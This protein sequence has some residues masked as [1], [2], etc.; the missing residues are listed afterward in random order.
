MG[1]VKKTPTQFDWAESVEEIA[2]DLIPKYH[3]HLVNAK[4]AYLFK[5][6]EIKRGGKIVIA[7]AEKCGPKVKALAEYDF[8]ITVAYPTYQELTDK[9]KTAVVDHELEHCFVDE[10]DSGEVKLKIITHDFEEFNSIIRRHGL[11]KPDLVTM[12]KA[13]TDQDDLDD[14]EEEDVDPLGLDD[15]DDEE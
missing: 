13:V 14:D 6:K 4:I 9:Q 12:S 1:Q 5:N 7:T 8:I 15:E 3:T 10:D 11:W 2:K